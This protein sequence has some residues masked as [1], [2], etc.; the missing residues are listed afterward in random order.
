MASTGIGIGT[1]LKLFIGGT[2]IT[3]NKVVSMNIPRDTIDV[4][5]KDSGSDQDLVYGRRNGR[6]FNVE[7]LFAEDA[8][9]GFED[10][11]D[12]SEAGTVLTALW[13]SAVSG[14]VTYSA[15]VLVT[16]LVKNA[17]DQEAESFT[18]TLAITGA[19]TKSTVA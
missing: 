5:T 3:H 1:V 6:T 15:S 13:S 9:Y 12:A 17:G 2:A 7:S 11:F 16:N 10:L 14:D 18:C 8:A 4:S 19:I